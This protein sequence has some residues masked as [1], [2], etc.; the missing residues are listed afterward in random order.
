M[1]KLFASLFAMVLCGSITAQ[2][3]YD[4]ETIKK[5]NLNRGVVA[6][7]QADGKGSDPVKSV[8]GNGGP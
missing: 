6:I 4:M 7:K 8:A 1:K 2:P 3:R 5:E